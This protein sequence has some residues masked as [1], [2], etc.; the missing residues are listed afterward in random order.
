MK[1]F[2]TGIL[3]AAAMFVGAAAHAGEITVY[4]SYEED[5]VKAY[6][7]AF[8]K[9]HPDV[10]V[11][12]LRLSTGDLGARMLAEASNPKHD[13]IWG[14]AVT[15]MVDPRIL[16]LTE[17]YAPKAVDKMNARFRDPQNRW[18]ATTGYMAAFCVNTDVLTKKNL[19]VPASWKDLLDPRYK[20]EILMPNPASSGTGYLQVVALLQGMG[21][22][23][24]WKYLKDLDANISQ[25]IKSGSRPCRMAIAGEAAIGLSYEFVA[26]KAIAGG[27]PIKM[28][29][30]SEGAGYELEANALMKASKNKADAKTFLDW[31]ITPEAVA[32]Y[33]AY[34]G[35]V[36]V[37]GGKISEEAMKAGLPADVS[38]VL[39]KMDF[40]ASAKN[41]D[42][43]L[44]RWKKDLER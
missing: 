30:P 25:Y 14:W 21:E 34:K 5:E 16:E 6:L 2:V 42:A 41:R 35:I 17:S 19:P 12:V 33:N 39:F 43:I 38:T 3:A 11:N 24:G 27:A 20:G 26:I 1:R 36:T 44:E 28:V 31:S 13:V 9:S 40:E 10:K 29:I 22:Q 23:A 18:V 8:N 32:A 37:P 7:Q 4:T 15:N